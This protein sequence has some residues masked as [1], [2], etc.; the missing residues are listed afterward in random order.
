MSFIL[1]A[2]RKLEQKRQQGSVPDL[3]TV[4]LNASQEQKKRSI[5]PYVILL[6]LV[7][8]AGVITALL[9]TDKSEKQEVL[10]E[11]NSEQKETS[12]TKH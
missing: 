4:H 12:V 1:D 3:T 8:N 9:I 5:L 2:L 11:S 10:L 7:I 6:V